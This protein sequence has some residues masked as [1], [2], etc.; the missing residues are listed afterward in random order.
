MDGSVHGGLVSAGAR[1]LV[2]EGFVAGERVLVDCTPRAR[3]VLLGR[4]AGEVQDVE[5]IALAGR[6]VVCG[7]AVVNGDDL[8]GLVLLAANNEATQA[9]GEVEGVKVVA[10]LRRALDV[11]RQRLIGHVELSG[12]V[13]EE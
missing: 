11:P 5:G 1:G 13:V 6:L 12:V 8:D 4:Q 7:E 3:R 10:G 9:I 2:F